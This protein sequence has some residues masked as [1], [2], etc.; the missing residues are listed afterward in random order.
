MI[1]LA[2]LIIGFACLQ[3]LIAGVNACYRLPKKDLEVVVDE[4]LLSVLIPARNEAANIPLLLQDLQQQ[5]YR[6]LEILVFDDLSTDGTADIVESMILT[7]PRI[8]LIRSA[9]LP[10]GWLGKN[11]ACHR[12]ATE[13]QG[14][15]F[16]FL[17]ADVRV[18]GDLIHRALTMA[19]YRRT[20]LLSMF[21][22]QQMLSIGEWLTV[23]LMNY[24]LLTLLPLPLVLKSGFTSL[25]A[26]N[27]QFMLFS[28]SSYLSTQPHSLFQDNKVEDI[29]IARYFKAQKL[30]VV[31]ITS[32][33]TLSCRMYQSA[34]EAV[35]GFSKNMLSFFGNSVV[36]A[37][38]FWLFTT[39]GIVAVMLAFP[40][41]II[42]L[43]IL[44]QIVTRLLVSVGSYQ[45]GFMNILLAIPQQWM[46]G[47][48]MLKALK[49]KHKKGLTWKGRT[50]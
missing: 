31:C 26:A 25:A 23:P 27:G 46:M 33:R 39:L 47:Y 35:N 10:D 4:P 14:G 34:T 40:Y 1:Y 15:Y 6:H 20:A 29:S 42:L 37:A 28:R 41:R 3:C 5:N 11:Y 50:I 38:L 18:K 48:M 19:M 24:I 43:F 17:D 22:A 44:I 8:R 2:S 49:F 9:G 30:P 16:L 12:L 45:S 13:A 36:G 32:D 7:D 21:P